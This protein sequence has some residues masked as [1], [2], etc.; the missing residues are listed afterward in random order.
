[1]PLQSGY[2]KE[3]ITSNIKELIHAGY[4]RKQAIAIAYAKARESKKK[5]KGDRQ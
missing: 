4:S 3:A 1:M 2:S 5:E